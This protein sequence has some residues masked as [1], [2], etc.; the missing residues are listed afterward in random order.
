MKCPDC[1]VELMAPCKCPEH[2]HQPGLEWQPGKQEGTIGCPVCG[3]LA[4]EAYWR[5]LTDETKAAYQ[6]VPFKI[7]T[8]FLKVNPQ[9]FYAMFT[10]NKTF[11]IRKNDRDFKQGHCIIFQMWTPDRGYCNRSMSAEIVNITDYPEGLRPGYV[12]LGIRKL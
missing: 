12:V 4:A 7:K 2:E 10:L 11:S 9:S 1:G 3:F 8:H 5:A 6:N